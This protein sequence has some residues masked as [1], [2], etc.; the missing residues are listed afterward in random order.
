MEISYIMIVLIVIPPYYDPIKV[1]TPLLAP[2][3]QLN[4]LEIT[5]GIREKSYLCSFH[6]CIYQGEKEMPQTS[7]GLTIHSSS[8]SF[9][10]ALRENGCRIGYEP[11]RMSRYHF[12]RSISRDTNMEVSALAPG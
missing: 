8:L 4:T 1:I 3:P 11:T 2:Y 9:K 10:Y 7:I 6:V 5:G 12:W